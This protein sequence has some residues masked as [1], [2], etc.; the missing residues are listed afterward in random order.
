[1]ATEGAGGSTHGTTS[2]GTGAPHDPSHDPPHDPAQDPSQDPGHEQSPPG[3]EGGTAH[4]S[5]GSSTSKPPSPPPVAPPPPPPAPPTP[6]APDPSA[7]AGAGATGGSGGGAASAAGDAGAGVRAKPPK[8]LAEAAA[9]FAARAGDPEAAPALGPRAGGAPTRGTADVVSRFREAGEDLAGSWRGFV[10]KTLAAE[11]SRVEGRELDWKKDGYADAAAGL[12]DLAATLK[13]WQRLKERNIFDGQAMTTLATGLLEDLQGLQDLLLRRASDFDAE[14]QALLGKAVEALSA[15]LAQ[16][17]QRLHDPV[18]TLLADF[19]ALAQPV[20]LSRVM[21][22]R[23]DAKLKTTTPG[24]FWSDLKAALRI[25]DASLARQVDAVFGEGLGPALKRWENERHTL[26]ESKALALNRQLCDILASYDEQLATIDAAATGISLA[27]RSYLSGL[28]EGLH[29]LAGWVAADTRARAAA[30]DFPPPLIPQPDPPASLRET[31]QAFETMKP[32]EASEAL[33]GGTVPLA[34][35]GRALEG[36]WAD[37]IDVITA[38]AKQGIESRQL[39]WVKDGYAEAFDGLPDLGPALKRWR[40]AQER[41]LFDRE[42]LLS[43]ANDLLLELKDAKQYVTDNESRFIGPQVIA[44][45]GGLD[46]LAAELARQV[47]GLEDP[48]AAAATALETLAK[49]KLPPSEWRLSCD[50]QLKSGACT[51]LWATALK[52]V[53]AK[54][55][56]QGA[57]ALKDIFAGDPAKL[58]QKWQDSVKAR[59]LDP[60]TI[61]LAT[62]DLADRLDSLDTQ[63]AAAAKA[64]RLAPPIAQGLRDAV[65][66]I[67]GQV[68]STTVFL[69]RHNGFG[70]TPG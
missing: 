18:Q 9:R 8:T 3:L 16:Q 34:G 15:E 70:S 40:K 36:R 38:A 69:G 19:D 25:A 60:T 67:A 32:T 13:E 65:G 28:R 7:A 26:T 68:A 61:M 5:G 35:A 42:A 20:S 59:S 54:A 14:V 30:G 11:R 62:R 48:V 17:A 57:A 51:E 55:D 24:A 37:F 43:A 44:L 27:D 6:P 58:M 10:D 41:D 64:A 21:R 49:P 52:R 46:M 45:Q 66:A 53:A 22:D 50:Q 1:M 56:A 63:L 4:V 2:G 12:P 47:G 31:A 39:D 33:G 29:A 23:F